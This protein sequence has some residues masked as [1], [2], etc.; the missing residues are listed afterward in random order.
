MNTPPDGSSRSNTRQDCAGALEVARQL[1]RMIAELAEGLQTLDHY[2]KRI[3]EGLV[4]TLVDHLE[5][6]CDGQNSVREARIDE[7]LDESFPASD[8][9]SWT[10]THAGVRKHA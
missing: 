10:S 1:E 3:A 4:G 6:I 7:A 8:P 5:T 9:P 2:E